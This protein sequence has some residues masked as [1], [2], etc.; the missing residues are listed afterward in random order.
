MYET[1]KHYHPRAGL[2]CR[3]ATALTEILGLDR[4]DSTEVNI[5]RI[6]PHTTDPIELEQRRRTFWVAFCNDLSAN[7]ANG[8]PLSVD[9]DNVSTPSLALVYR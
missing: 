6:L 3:R 8:W 4:L 5:K 9:A 2:S 1:L 7:S